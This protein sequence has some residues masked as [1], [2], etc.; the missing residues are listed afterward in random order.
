MWSEI[1]LFGLLAF[2]IPLSFYLGKGLFFNQ[3][4]T[5]ASSLSNALLVGIAAFLIQAFFD[6]NFYALQASFLFW[7]FWG[8]YVGLSLPRDSSWFL[9]NLGYNSFYI[10]KNNVKPKSNAQRIIHEPPAQN[11]MAGL[12][13][14]LSLSHYGQ[15]RRGGG[16]SGDFKQTIKK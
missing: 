9:G 2:L 13:V 4:K 3:F 7:I 6:T 14:A 1:G 10:R 8:M 12:C 5:R 11:G 16:L 15:A